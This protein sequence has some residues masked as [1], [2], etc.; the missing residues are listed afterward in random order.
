MQIYGRNIS[1]L[2]I[3]ENEVEI[4]SNL[5]HLKDADVYIIAISDDAI[6]EFSS[7][8]NLKGKLVVHTSGSVAM[9][10]L[11]TT[12]NKGVFYPLQTF[13]VHHKIDFSEV[14]V[15]IETENNKDLLL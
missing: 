15:C 6:S 4:T 9:K 1:S 14:P 5:D 13:S 8:L 3:F 11:K 10:A 12:A 2:K 7:Q